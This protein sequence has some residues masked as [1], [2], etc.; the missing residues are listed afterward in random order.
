MTHACNCEPISVSPIPTRGWLMAGLNKAAAYVAA[1]WQRRRHRREIAALLSHDDYML[2][3]IGLSRTDVLA[4]VLIHD[5]VDPG[6]RLAMARNER[7][8]AERARKGVRG[9]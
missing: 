5:E 6:T 7:H 4:A 2:K 1:V 8:Q 3:D 9:A